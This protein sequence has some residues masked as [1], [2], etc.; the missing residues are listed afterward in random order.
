MSWKVRRWHFH[1]WKVIVSDLVR[2]NFL[3]RGRFS[4][5]HFFHL[6]HCWGWRLGVPCI[7]VIHLCF[8]DLWLGQVGQSSQAGFGLDRP[9][10]CQIRSVS[11]GYVWPGFCLVI[12]TTHLSTSSNRDW[13]QPIVTLTSEPFH[14]DGFGMGKKREVNLLT[15]GRLRWTK[16]KKKQKKQKNIINNLF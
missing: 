1:R 2:R 15:K 12:F 13:L 6:T 14:W 8:A 5:N 3:H 10:L 16:S 4:E 7:S 9:S 11:E